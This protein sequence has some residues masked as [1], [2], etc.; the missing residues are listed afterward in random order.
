MGNIKH[1]HAFY[2]LILL[3]VSGTSAAAPYITYDYVGLQYTN[4]KLDD[5]D[6]TQDGLRAYGNLDID[7]DWFAQASIADVS[8]NRGCGSSTVTAGAGYRAEYNKQFDMYGT[9]S[10]EST[11]PDNGDSDSGI[12]MAAGLRG[13]IAKNLEGRL[14][15]AHHTIFDGET[16]VNAGVAYWITPIF[17]ATFDLQIDSN[18]RTFAGGVRMLF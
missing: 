6:C 18:G 17:S 3:V 15:L 4:Q 13:I 8:G 10:F 7:G 1:F 11:S 12:I 9:L 5:Y 2:A 16:G 14:E